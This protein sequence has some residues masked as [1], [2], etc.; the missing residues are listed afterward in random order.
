[1]LLIALLVLAGFI[2]GW[3]P[4][5][6]LGPSESLAAVALVALTL[7]GLLSLGGLG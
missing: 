7:L 2:L 1:M 3:K 5:R 4:L 6:T